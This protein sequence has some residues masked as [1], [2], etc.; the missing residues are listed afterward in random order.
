MDD[1]LSVATKFGLFWADTELQDEEGQALTDGFYIALPERY[2]D[3]FFPLLHKLQQLN[4]YCFHQLLSSERRLQAL[5]SQRQDV[6]AQKQGGAEAWIYLDDQIPQWEDNVE[7]VGRATSIVLLSSFV[8]WGLK[9][10]ALEFCGTIPRKRGGA[11]SDVE[12]ML[13]HLQ[14]QGG[15][16][17]AMEVE[18][19]ER[20]HSFRGIR[21]AFAHGDWEALNA[22]LQSVSLRAC[23]TAV[24]RLFHCL[25]ASAWQGPWQHPDA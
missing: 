4:D 12:F 13:Q 17:P 11:M 19:M 20:I 15:L 14:R 21:N 10:V 2:S 16:S 24:A 22:Q 23:F 8:E 5:V 7:V 1:E 3:T 9:R 6:A 25:E 18:C